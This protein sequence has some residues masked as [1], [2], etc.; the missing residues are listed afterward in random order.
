MKKYLLGSVVSMLV[1]SA[2][3]APNLDNSALDKTVTVNSNNA[4]TKVLSKL[5]LKLPQLVSIKN[6][7]V[8]P[9]SKIKNSFVNSRQPI[10]SSIKQKS[11][12]ANFDILKKALTEMNQIPNYNEAVKIGRNAAMSVLKDLNDHNDPHYDLINILDT[13]L[14]FARVQEM[15]PDNYDKD[16]VVNEYKTFLYAFNWL[17]KAG[18]AHGG[19]PK[20]LAIFAYNMMLEIQKDTKMSEI[21]KKR[22]GF[23]VGDFALLLYANKDE[24]NDYQQVAQDAIN[25][26]DNVGTIGALYNIV[27][28][29]ISSISGH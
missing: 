27:F 15:D 7:P 14:M 8:V 9:K 17:I 21:I 28:S 20:N 25:S 13:T 11:S 2:C 4:G 18:P 29:V 22:D 23:Y 1:V 6:P 5:P 3:S 12:Q 24:Y 19:H 10:N 26:Y 16:S